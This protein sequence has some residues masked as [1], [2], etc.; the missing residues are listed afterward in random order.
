MFAINH[1]NNNNDSAACRSFVMNPHPYTNHNNDSAVSM[2]FVMDPHPCTNH[3]NDSAISKSWVMDPH[4][5]T[6]HDTDSAVM[7]WYADKF[8]SST[9]SR[10][11][12]PRP[13]SFPPELRRSFPSPPGLRWRSFP[14]TPILLFVS[15]PIIVYILD[16]SEYSSISASEFNTPHELIC[17][18]VLIVISFYLTVAR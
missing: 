8:S 13:R 2:S 11:S 16:I 15:L 9:L 17:R 14:S 7:N 5:Y 1:N 12:F 3:D 10:V 4:S 18:Q 6:N